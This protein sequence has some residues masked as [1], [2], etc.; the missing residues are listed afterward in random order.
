MST[1][2]P[3]IFSGNANKK[4]AKKIANEWRSHIQNADVKQFSDGEISVQINSNV[5]GRDCFIIQPTCAPTNDNLM[6]LL[7]MADTLK[8]SSCARLIGVVPYYGYS[9]QDK[10]A[11]SKRVPITARLVADMLQG[12]GFDQLITMDL[13][14]DQLQGFFNIP[15]DNIYASPVLL[16]DIKDQNNLDNVILVAPDTGAANRTRAIAQ[17]LGV[18]MAIIDK[19]REQ[20]NV[21]E[22]MHVIGDVGGK[23]CI[24]IDDMIDTAGT[25]CN[26]AK[27][28][29]EHGATGVKAYATHF[30]GSGPALDNID[31]S[32]LQEVVVTDTILSTKVSTKRGKIRKV[33]VAPLLAETMRRVHNNESISQLFE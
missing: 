29:I 3:L 16:Q 25:M 18:E 26:G 1:A 31:A 27:A 19:R 15:V 2:P 32:P 33:S 10:M 28:L 30:V 6:E 24:F 21:S 4:L 22:V 13:H 20:A 7:I 11:R 14:S 8:R 23:F 12:A 17:G 9:R 5:R